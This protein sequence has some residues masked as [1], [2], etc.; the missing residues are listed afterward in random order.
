MLGSWP[1]FF[2]HHHVRYPCV[3]EHRSFF[4]IPKPFVEFA[5]GELRTENDFFGAS[6]GGSGR[7]ELH[8]LSP[9]P[10]IS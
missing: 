1:K 3:I 2:A 7:G 6:T 8:Q 4:C 5:C 10:L 9:N